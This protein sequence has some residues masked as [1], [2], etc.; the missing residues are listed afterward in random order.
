M[1]RDAAGTQIDLSTA[2]TTVWQSDDLADAIEASM[3]D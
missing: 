2:A 3:P 1:A